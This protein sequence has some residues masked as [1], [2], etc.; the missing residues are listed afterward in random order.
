MKDTF[1]F[2]HDCNARQD[3]KILALRMKLG[4]E[5][6]GLYWALIERLRESAGYECVKDYN[7]IAFDLRVPANIIKSIVEDFGLFTFTEDGKR[8][9]SNRL[10][11][12][13][14]VKDEISA[15]RSAAGKKGMNNRY[16]NRPKDTTDESD[17]VTKSQQS[18]NK[19]ITELQQS[20]NDDITIKEEERKEYNISSSLCSEESIGAKT[21]K[22]FCP[23]TPEEV[24]AYAEE[25]GYTGFDAERF[26]DFYASKGWMV[27]KNKMKDWRAAVRNWHKSN[28]DNPNPPKHSTKH[29]NDEW[30]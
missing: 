14:N 10:S 11:K 9:Y 26:V 22:R 6:Y 30:T 25:R 4:W 12:D 29:I 16:K 13:M 23:P 3:E 27:G 7:V 15:S 2:R 8:F 19:A 28:S 17:G 1:Y 5:G 18:Y 20:Y 21:D 24:R